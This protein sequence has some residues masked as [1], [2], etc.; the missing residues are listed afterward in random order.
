MAAS[1]FCKFVRAMYYY[2]KDVKKLT[3]ISNDIL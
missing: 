3:A 2:G 1:A